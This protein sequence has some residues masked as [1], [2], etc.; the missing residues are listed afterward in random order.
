LPKNILYKKIT[1]IAYNMKGCLKFS[2]FLL[3][4]LPK[5]TKYT[6]KWQPLEQKKKM[7]IGNEFIKSTNLYKM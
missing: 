7:H 5:L 4:I 6:Y 3:W 2:A 1:T